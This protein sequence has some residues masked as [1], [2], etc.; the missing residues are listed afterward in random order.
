MD[1]FLILLNH[2]T[3]NMKAISHIN[4]LVFNAGFF[5][6]KT[7][8]KSQELRE[9]IWTHKRCS[10]W[11]MFNVCVIRCNLTKRRLFAEMLKC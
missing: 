2:F 10:G 6:N 11:K 7:K 1:S 3:R 4:A 5:K 9:I 8:Q